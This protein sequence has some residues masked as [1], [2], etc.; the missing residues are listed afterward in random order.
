MRTKKLTQEQCQ[1]LAE[2]FPVMSNVEVARLLNVGVTTVKNYADILE[3]SKDPVYI[4]NMRKRVSIK[5]HYVRWKQSR[6]KQS[7][8]EA[9]GEEK[10]K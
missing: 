9:L 8:S 3:L 10:L 6:T 5:G 4:S 1:L 2:K 7:G